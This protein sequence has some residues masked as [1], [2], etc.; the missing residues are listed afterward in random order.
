MANVAKEFISW[1][2]MIER[3]VILNWNQVNFV[4]FHLLRAN[5]YVKSLFYLNILDEKLQ[6]EFLLFHRL[7][8]T[9]SY[10]NLAISTIHQIIFIFPFCWFLFFREV[11]LHHHHVTSDTDNCKTIKQGFFQ[12]CN[13]DKISWYAWKVLIFLMDYK[14]EY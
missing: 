7:I 14:V 9:R 3:D 6:R 8:L 13:H 2:Y 12:N 11:L 5:L 1:S 10:Y 4:K